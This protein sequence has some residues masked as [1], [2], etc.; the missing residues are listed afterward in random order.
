MDLETVAIIATIIVGVLV[1]GGYLFGAVRTARKR[2]GRR[3]DLYRR[4]ETLTADVHFDY[5]VERLGMGGHA[6]KDV[7]DTWVE[8]I[9]ADEFAY[10]Q[11]VTD[12][13]G[14]VLFYS[15][16]S[17]D[18]DFKP[19]IWPRKIPRAA[20]PMLPLKNLGDAS[21]AETGENLDLTAVEFFI[22][23]ATAPSHYLEAYYLGN[24]GMYR[25]YLVGLNQAGTNFFEESAIST[26][27]KRH[28]SP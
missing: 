19:R 16:T 7:A 5:F 12:A 4:L 8:Y 24:P 15:V 22:S 23:G 9:F 27:T 1:V 14:R 18:D 3:S 2:L 10:V 20:N 17:H 21:F 6:F 28:I 26:H 11:V 13:T 25:T